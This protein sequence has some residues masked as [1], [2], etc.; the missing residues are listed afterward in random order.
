MIPDPYKKTARIPVIMTDDGL[1]FF[2]GGNLPAIKEG[3]IA[4]LIVPEYCVL[5]QFKLS[6]IKKDFIKPFLSEGTILMARLSERSI[7]KSDQFLRRINTFPPKVGRFAKIIL[8]EELKIKFRGTKNPELLECNCTI[9]ALKNEKVKSVNHAFTLISEKFEEHRTSHTGNVFEQVYFNEN[10]DVWVRLHERRNYLFKEFEYELFCLCRQWWY[11][12]SPN[13]QMIW[14]CFDQKGKSE[15]T[16]YIISM[17]SEILSEHYFRN[18]EE[19][20]NWFNKNGYIKFDTQKS[21]ESII[22]PF[23]PYKKQNGVEVL[24]EYHIGI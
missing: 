7:D 5:D 4:D 14:G 12:N 24:L 11:N 13:N 22:P 19:T 1:K 23:P 16:V 18:D 10:S 6:L 2:Y 20:I 21:S 9:P 17:D 3:A 15:F 8:D